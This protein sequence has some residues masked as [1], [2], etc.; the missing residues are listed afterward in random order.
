[1]EELEK[2]LTTNKVVARDAFTEAESLRKNLSES[3]KKLSAMQAALT[4]REKA[5]ADRNLSIEVSVRQQLQLEF[6][7]SSEY[8]EEE[9]KALTLRCH[10]L[11]QMLAVADQQL[12]M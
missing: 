2:E 3:S 11:S 8:C 6:N 7:K 1:M 12:L 5:E 4:T 10:E 9:K